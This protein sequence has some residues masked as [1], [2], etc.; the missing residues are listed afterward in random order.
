MCSCVQLHTTTQIRF[1]LREVKPLACH[2]AAIEER[3]RE[4]WNS[5]LTHRYVSGIL[6]FVFSVQRRQPSVAMRGNLNFTQV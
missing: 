4:G 1:R 5:G 2:H 3:E 6:S